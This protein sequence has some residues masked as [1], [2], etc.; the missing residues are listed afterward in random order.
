ME[1]RIV[2][3]INTIHTHLFKV[4]IMRQMFPLIRFTAL[5]ERPRVF[6]LVVL[7]LMAFNLLIIFYWA[8]TKM[9]H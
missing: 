4:L 7:V 9:L 3:N 1:K 2:R 6:R 8:V 5:K